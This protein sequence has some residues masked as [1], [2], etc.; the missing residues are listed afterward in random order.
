MAGSEG[1]GGAGLVMRGAGRRIGIAVSDV[2][3]VVKLEL[4][5][6]RDVPEGAWEDDL[7]LGLFVR[8]GLLVALLDAR[9]L[10]SACQ[11][12]PVPEAL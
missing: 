7:L 9:S 3:D 8:G 11:T 6:I 10:V 12:A 5:T 2:E 4:A 1:S